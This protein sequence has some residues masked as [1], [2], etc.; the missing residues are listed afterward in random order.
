MRYQHKNG[1]ILTKIEESDLH[2]LKALKDESHYGTHGY[3]IIN[4]FDEKKWF[5]KTSTLVLKAMVDEVGSISGSFYDPKTGRVVL[6][7]AEEQDKIIGIFKIDHVDTVNRTCDVGWDVFSWVRGK[8]YG[9]KLVQTG[10]DFCFEIL[11]LNRLDA[12]ILEN[13]VASQKCAETAGFIKEGN[14]RKSV[15]K[16]IEYIDSWIYGILRS[17]W[18]LQSDEIRNISYTPKNGI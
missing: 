16:C 1:L 7:T 17:E 13:N 8:G 5:E 14:R 6:S 2:L 15:Y 18:T 9:K 12:E 10:V 4:R 11:N 3:A